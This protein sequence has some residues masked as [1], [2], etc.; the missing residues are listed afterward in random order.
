MSPPHPKRPSRAPRAPGEKASRPEQELDLPFDDDEVAP[1][2]ADDPRP[3]RVPQFPAGSRRRPRRGAAGA[4]REGKD[5]E[6][7]ARFTSGEYEDPG[8]SHVFLYVER[9]PGAGQLLPIKQGTLLIGRAST[10][11]LRLQHPSISRRHAQL[12]RRDE[13]LFLKDLGSQNGTY[14]NRSRITT[15]LEL[16][17]GDEISVGNAVLRIRGP[18]YVPERAPADALG[19]GAEH[20]SG[21]EPRRLL[22]VTVMTAGA[23]A[24][25]FLTAGLIRSVSARRAEPRSTARTDAPAPVAALPASELPAS[26]P[27][28]P[29]AS[30]TVSEPTPVVGSTA[31]TPIRPP[32]TAPV[33]AELVVGSPRGETTR[34]PSASRA[35]SRE[36][37][38]ASVSGPKGASPTG[39][40]AAAQSEEE[41]LAT[42]EAGQLDAALAQ[43]RG[44]RMER[45]VTRLKQFQDAWRAGTAALAARDSATAL[46]HL[47]VARDV[48]QQLAGGWGAFAPKIR[49]ALKQAQGTP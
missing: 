32:Q 33:R 31:P 16:L 42:Y 15:E 17:A 13:H 49:E 7:P 34:T 22:M 36:K 14:V 26:P 46:K 12:T 25:L 2:Q 41:V 8:H 11:D 45:L 35:G 38:A 19:A 1:L 9:G 3:Q 43:A 27:G 10:S 20:R 39:A 28:P 21:W 4:S 37:G 30:A 5:R 40:V 23:L 48:D 24:A 29:E 44:A 18:G 6:L 47:T